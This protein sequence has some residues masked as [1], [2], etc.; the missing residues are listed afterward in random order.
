VRLRGGGMISGSLRGCSG[1]I[2]RWR[3]MAPT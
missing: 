2:G 3:G 1:L